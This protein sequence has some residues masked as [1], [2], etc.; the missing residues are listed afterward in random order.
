MNGGIVYLE[1]IILGFIRVSL[2]NINISA[3]FCQSL[4]SSH[5]IH[6]NFQRGIP[7]TSSLVSSLVSSSISSLV[8]SSSSSLLSSSSLGYRYSFTTIVLKSVGLLG[9]YTLYISLSIPS[10]LNRLVYLPLCPVLPSRHISTSKLRGRSQIIVIDRPFHQFSI[11]LTCFFALIL[12]I[13][14]IAFFIATARY[15][16]EGAG[17]SSSLI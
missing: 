4:I 6:F 16:I 9:S 2:I 13:S 15:I 12:T 8:S 14:S 1:V 5:Y 17:G 10:N 7:A 11:S 3:V